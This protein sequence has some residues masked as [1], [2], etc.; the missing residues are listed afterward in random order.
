MAA[1]RFL[2]ATVDLHGDLTGEDHAEVESAWDDEIAK[3]V[4]EIK[5]DSARLLTSEEFFGVFAEA[6]ATMERI[7]AV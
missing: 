7:T 5:S 4:D 3:R 1:G 2:P 6:R